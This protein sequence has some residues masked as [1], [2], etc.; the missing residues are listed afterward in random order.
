MQTVSLLAAF[1]DTLPTIKNLV[2][3][4]AVVVVMVVLVMKIVKDDHRTA[5][6]MV[7]L[8]GLVL[9]LGTVAGATWVRDV[10]L[11]ALKFVLGNG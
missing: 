6:K 10:T 11:S 8:T 9:I 1:G 4:A 2:V 5:W 7:P 3:S